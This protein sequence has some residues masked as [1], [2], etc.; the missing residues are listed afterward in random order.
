MLLISK[1]TPKRF[2]GYHSLWQYFPFLPSFPFFLFVSFWILRV[3]SYLGP[4]R[5][6]ERE[7][8]KE[9]IHKYLNSIFISASSVVVI[10]EKF[11]LGSG[12][13][14]YQ[15]SSKTNDYT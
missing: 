11:C 6:P 13:F 7:Y 2:G 15:L 1:R 10:V 14:F 8:L 5:F 4:D 9:Q 12:C 3:V